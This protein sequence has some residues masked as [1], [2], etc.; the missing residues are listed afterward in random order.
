[1]ADDTIHLDNTIFSKLK[2][3]GVLKAKFFEVGKK[4]DDKKADEDND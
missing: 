2:K 4:A 1:M 3:E